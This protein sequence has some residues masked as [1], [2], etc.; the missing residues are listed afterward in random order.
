MADNGLATGSPELFIGSSGVAN[1][2]L[3]VHTQNNVQTAIATGIPGGTAGPS[4][5]QNNLAPADFGGGS[6]P[7][8]YGLSYTSTFAAIYNL[9]GTGAVGPTNPSGAGSLSG[10]FRIK[11]PAIH[12]FIAPEF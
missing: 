4:S 1:V 9:G 12:E 5:A 2:W 6:S 3:E 8:A 10:L 7:L 11:N